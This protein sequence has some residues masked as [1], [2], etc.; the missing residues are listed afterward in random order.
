MMYN[1]EIKNAIQKVRK[2]FNA[3]YNTEENNFDYISLSTSIPLTISLN[4]ISFYCILCS[5]C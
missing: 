1:A 3:S 5:F 2:C 4:N